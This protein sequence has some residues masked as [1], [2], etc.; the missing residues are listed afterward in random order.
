MSTPHLTSIALHFHRLTSFSPATV[1]I[2]MCTQ[3]N[4]H[5][6]ETLTNSCSFTRWIK[7]HFTQDLN[8]KD[9][10]HHIHTLR[11][12][13]LLL[14][15]NLKHIELSEKLISLNYDKYSFSCTCFS[16][17]TFYQYL[18]LVGLTKL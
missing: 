3:T 13:Q 14:K 2:Q 5:R 10:Q 11:I 4:N 15:I 7:A 16:D 9:M 1:S 12:F 6:V 8:M 17:N 18:S